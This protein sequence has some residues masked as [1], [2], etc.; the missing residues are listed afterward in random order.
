MSKEH[1]LALT[2]VPRIG[3]VT[4]RK[5]L[6]RFGSIE[7]VFAAPVADIAAVPR[8]SDDQARQLLAASLDEMG[9]QLEA[10][11]D[12]GIDVLTWDDDAYPANLR[13]VND[14]PPVLFVR[15]A[16]VPSDEVAVAIVGS[17]EATPP[18]LALAER[19]GCELAGRGLTVVSGLALGID[20]AAHRGALAARRGRTLAVLGSGLAAIF[21]PAHVQLAEEIA[22]RGA[23]LSELRPRTPATGPSLMARDRI[24]SG[25]SRAVIVVEARAQSGSMDTARRAEAQKRLLVAAPGSDGCDALL[26]Q[27]AVPLAADADLDELAQ[28]VRSYAVGDDAAQ[29]LGLV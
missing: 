24:V 16:L 23:L 17:R 27:G 11:A 19:L 15:G 5:L 14:A 13:A 21:P 9:A 25:L 7:A 1:W 10:L 12:A 26:R 4:V 6:E 3:G 29:Q 20:A 8:V 22:E 18:S 28:R 2:S